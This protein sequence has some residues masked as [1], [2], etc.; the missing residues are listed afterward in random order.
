MRKLAIALVLSV[1]AVPA[2]A[3]SWTTHIG[4]NPGSTTCGTTKDIPITPAKDCESARKSSLELLKTLQ[5]LGCAFPEC[6]PL[7]VANP[8]PTFGCTYQPTTYAN[9][10]KADGWLVSWTWDC[11][12]SVPISPPCC[13]CLGETSTVD[14]STGSGSSVDSRWKVNGGSAYILAPVAG[15]L[16][17][18]SPAKW[19][20]PTAN[21]SAQS[22]TVYKYTLTFSAPKCTIPMDVAL[23]GNVS[24]DNNATVFLDGQQIA[25][26]PGPK[27][28]T[29][30]VPF[31]V[32]SIAPGN[33]TLEI[34]VG[35]DSGGSGLIVS[36]QLKVQCKKD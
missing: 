10:T 6:P 14:L 25:S 26:C 27:C 21:G 23:E 33:H 31:N 5:S 18:L 22:N 30:A 32:P 15:W 29:T 16:T 20:Q 12:K 2:G 17:T 8:Q 24:A 19:I 3:Q 28:F 9:G 13:K 7:D 35:N 11:K 4:V 1:L 36:A 34:Q